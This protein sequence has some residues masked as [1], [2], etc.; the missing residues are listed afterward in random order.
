M[1]NLR[2]NGILMMAT[3]M[4]IFGTIG[5]FR[6]YIPLSSEVLACA[7]GFLGGTFLLL[8]LLIKNKAVTFNFTTPQFFLLSFIGLMLGSNWILLFE[9]YSYTSI[10]VATLCYYMAPTIVIL[11]SPIVFGEK[12]T[13]KKIICAAI[14]LLGIGMVSGVGGSDGVGDLR[15][16]LFGLGAAVLY[17][18]I[19]ILNKKYPISDVY[20]KTIVQLYGAGILLVP[21]LFYTSSFTAVDFDAMAIIMLLIVGIIHTG[22]AYALYFG[23]LDKIKSQTVAMMSYMDPIFAILL[24][25]V[26]LQEAVTVF[27]MIGAVMVIGSAFVSERA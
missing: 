4:L 26:F 1:N 25:A 10:A 23:S 9:A 20:G 18:A 6:K 5:I 11:L 14:A 12:L 24:A 22:I 13:K 2:N 7:R 21:Y 8:C 17:A 16:V 3:A 27:T 15:G 19:V